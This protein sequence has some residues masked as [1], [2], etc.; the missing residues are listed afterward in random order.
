MKRIAIVAHGLSNGGAERVATILANNLYALN[1][2]VLYISAYTNDRVYNLAEGIDYICIKKRKG[3]ISRFISRTIEIDSAIQRYNCDTVISFIFK[4]LLLSSIKG[5][6]PLV[7]SL[8][9]DPAKVTKSF[10]N[11]VLCNFT[12]SRAKAIVFQTPGARDF[13]KQKIKDKGFVIGNPIT[14]NLPFWNESN[15]D[16]TI[17]TACRLT[18]QKN[19]PMLIHGFAVF[20][21]N[22]SDYS[23]WIYGQGELKNKLISISKELGVGDK[24]HFPG[25]AENIHEIMTHSSIFA[26]TSDYEGLSNSMLEALAIGVPTVCT[27]CPPGGPSLYIND[28]CNGILVPV[29][30]HLALANAFSEI[31]SDIELAKRLSKNSV[32]IRNEL[33]EDRIIKM[34]E[35]LL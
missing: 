27:D 23:L 33:S 21:K 32:L 25:Y 2:K 35:S 3:K 6:I 20:S 5:N 28:H 15:C 4:E 29:R 10:V 24:V 14:P 17:V 1:Y 9:N 30:D 8:R 16:K 12:Y 13:F 7:F 31:A 11:R 22:H 19:I 26:L 18:E 34:W